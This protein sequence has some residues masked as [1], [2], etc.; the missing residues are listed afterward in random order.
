[1][2]FLVSECLGCVLIIDP[3]KG[4]ATD[5]SWYSDSKTVDW[6]LQSVRCAFFTVTSLP[7]YTTT[8]DCILV[9]FIKGV[10]T[11]EVNL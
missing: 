2:P 7:S 9:L 8:A 6:N 5:P 4:M 10:S 3:L 1:M 11:D